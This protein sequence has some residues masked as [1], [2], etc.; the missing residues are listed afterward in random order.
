MA[1]VSKLLLKRRS[2]GFLLIESVIAAS[3]IA[4]FALL[5]VPQAVRMYREA[6]LEYEAVQLLHT[7]RYVQ[8]LSH[9]TASWPDGMIPQSEEYVPS[10]RFSRTG[11]SVMRG[12]RQVVKSHSFP[13]GMTMVSTMTMSSPVYFGKEGTVDLPFSLRLRMEGCARDRQIVMSLSGRCRLD[14]V[15]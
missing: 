12:R 2:P 8:A 13:E 9:N 4:V 11:Y 7:I 6:V 10:L 14:R 1:G 3:V 15:G 5:A